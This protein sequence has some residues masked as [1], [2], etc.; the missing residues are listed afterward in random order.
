MYGNR[1]EGGDRLSRSSFSISAEMKKAD[2][3]AMELAEGLTN[4]ACIKFLQPSQIAGGFWMVRALKSLR[5]ER[6]NNQSVKQTH[7]HTDMIMNG[8]GA[9]PCK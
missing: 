5:M 1:G 7:L 4:P 2:E 8:I 9:L 3:K 6:E